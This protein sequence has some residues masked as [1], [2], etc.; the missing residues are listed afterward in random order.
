[1]N[2]NQR[3]M[4]IA[5]AVVVVVAVV[6]AVVLLGGGGGDSDDDASAGG[7]GGQ[8]NQGAAP[9][10]APA[11]TSAPAPTSAAAAPAAFTANTQQV[12]NANVIATDLGVIYGTC[13]YELST[14]GATDVEQSVSSSPPL[15]Q[16][17]TAAGYQGARNSSRTPAPCQGLP[18]SASSVAGN[19]RDVGAA[20]GLFTTARTTYV[21]IYPGATAFEAA[22]GQLDEVYCQHGVYPANNITGVTCWLRKG[23]FVGGVFILL[24]PNPAA[25]VEDEA[26]RDIA[27][28]LTRVDGV[29]R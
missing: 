14:N 13:T 17:M 21:A 9:T 20:Q 3:P 25:A 24:P 8:S 10:S 29:L 23:T 27:A 12:R 26:K 19:A 1:M 7:T 16:A 15:M 5:A 6:A 2:A 28:Y 22:K 18:Y 4:I 11:A